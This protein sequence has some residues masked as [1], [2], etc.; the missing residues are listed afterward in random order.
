MIIYYAVHMGG[1]NADVSYNA[2]FMGCWAYVEISLGIIVICSIPLPKLY[3]TKGKK[4]RN[5]LSDITRPFTSFSSLATLLRSA[6]HGTTISDR[7]TRTGA[8]KIQ[9][10][11]E[12]D[13]SLDLTTC[14]LSWPDVPPLPAHN[15]SNLTDQYQPKYQPSWRDQK[16]DATPV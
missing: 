10:P 4:V 3:E 15:L 14:H 11:S 1:D 6:R 5:F 2:A 8:T 7:T 16:Q 9:T 13:I 12:Y